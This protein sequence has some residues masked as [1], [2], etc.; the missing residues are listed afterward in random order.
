MNQGQGDNCAGCGRVKTNNLWLY[1]NFFI[2][3]KLC[4]KKI[5]IKKYV[6]YV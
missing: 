2:H 4:N 3:I 5:P 1:N 6:T